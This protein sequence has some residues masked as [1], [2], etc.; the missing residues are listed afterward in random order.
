MKTAWN[1][2]WD[3]KGWENK[4]P[5]GTTIQDEW[6]QTLIT[7]INQIS[8][9]INMAS[10]FGGADMIKIN[11]SLLPIF[12]SLMFLTKTDNGELFLS[13]KYKV[14]ID[15]KLNKD[16][17]YVYLNN[18]PDEP[19]FQDKNI[20]IHKNSSKLSEYQAIINNDSTLNLKVVSQR[21]LQ[22]KINI[23]NFITD[24]SLTEKPKNKS[25]FQKIIDL[26]KN[27]FFL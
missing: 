9:Q 13:D 20:F 24:E 22:G 11:S 14:V 21:K 8:A 26:F 18:V 12:E 27:K 5:K 10:S 4:F 19:V 1:L 16:R 6:N 15:N 17:I 3:Y 23:K 25:F 2:D 7:R